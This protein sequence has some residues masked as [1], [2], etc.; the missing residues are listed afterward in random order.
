MHSHHGLQEQQLLSAPLIV[1]EA[2]PGSGAQ[3][4]IL[5]LADFSFTPPEEI[6]ARLRDAKSM[7]NMSDME[8]T[9]EEMAAMP[10]MSGMAM[11]GGE[12]D[13]NDIDYDAF[14]A[15]YRTL[16]DPEVVKVEPGGRVLLRIINASAMSAYHIDLGQ[17]Q[18]E[19][20]AVDGHAI[21]PVP[22]RTFPI[23]VG[24]RLDIRLNVPPG[25]GAYPILATLEGGRK[26]TGVVLR[27]GSGA[28]T[29]IAEEAVSAT[30]A[31]TLG[32]ES[33]LRAATPLPPRPADRA[34]DVNLTGSMAGYQWSINDIAWTEAVPPLMVREGERVELSFVNKTGMAHPMHLHGH[35]VQVVAIN[36][37]R[38][39]GA[40]RDTVL[41]PPKTTVTIAFDANNPGWWAMHCH[42]AY[43]M[44]AGMFATVKYG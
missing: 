33:W 1:R 18:G 24:Q 43:H 19:L 10:G 27:A 31:I 7:A 13:I 38:F 32:L 39:A 21:V 41:A 2:G 16:R 29:K 8:M 35:D 23:V 22:G 3:D 15:N 34:Y 5:M 40:V 30:P 11:G 6:F 12:L 25:A 26:R 42:M 9:P 20:A 36:G 4:V 14:L 44:A 28:V 17:L 37:N